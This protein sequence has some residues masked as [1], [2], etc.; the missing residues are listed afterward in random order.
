M[1]QGGC[2][3]LDAY[4]QVGSHG[5]AGEPEPAHLGDVEQPG[6]RLSPRRNRWNFKSEI[7]IPK[8][9]DLH[10]Q[11]SYAPAIPSPSI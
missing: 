2:S 8:L 11:T 4:G 7:P 6:T 10:T 3:F 1:E 9:L 5:V